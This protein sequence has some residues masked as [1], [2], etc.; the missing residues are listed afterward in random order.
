MGREFRGE[1]ERENQMEERERRGKGRKEIRKERERGR[2]GGER[3]DIWKGKFWFRPKLERE[4]CISRH[5]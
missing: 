1:G 2:W 4:H 5:Q 3:R